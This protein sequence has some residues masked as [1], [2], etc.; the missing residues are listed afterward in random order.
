MKKVPK[1]QHC[2]HLKIH[3]ILRMLLQASTLKFPPQNQNPQ[4]LLPP[5]NLFLPNAPQAPEI[6][7]MPPLNRSHFKPKYSGK[8]DKDAE[9]H[10]LR[11]DEW[12]DTH[13]FPDQVKVQR[14][15]LTLVIVIVIVNF[16]GT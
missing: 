14:F 11:M 10:L 15:C 12:M 1:S 9:T 4:N 16:Y 7:H 6:Q 3:K 13:R 5:Q 2:K 8:P